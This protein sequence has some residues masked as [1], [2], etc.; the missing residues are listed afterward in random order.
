MTYQIEPSKEFLVGIDSDGCVFDTMELKHKEC[1]IPNIINYYELQ[2]VSKYAR[3]AAEFVNLYSKSRGIN[4]F[5][6]LIEAL[7]WLGKRPEVKARGY[8]IKIPQS[9]AQWVKEETKLGNPALEKKVAETGDAELKHCLEWSIAVN[10]M[11][12]GMVRGVPPFPYVRQSLEKLKDSA[13]MLVVSATPN[14]AL[15]AEW[16]EHDLSKYVTSICGQE[17]GNKKETLTNA[18]KYAENHTLMIGD[19]PGDYAAAKAN[20]CLFYPINPGDEENSWKRFEAEAIDKFL[21]GEFAGAYQK[22][23]LDEFDRYLPSRPSWPVE[24]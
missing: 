16:S 8:E 15:E 20:N 10:D 18:T 17:A 24:D 11:I 19:A 14:E 22:G 7:E 5:P 9:I 23:L 13:D 6:A 12:A 3:E 2:G 4:R 21:S 1:F